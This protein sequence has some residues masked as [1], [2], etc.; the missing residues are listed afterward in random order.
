MFDDETQ[1]ALMEEFFS[2]NRE[3]LGRIEKGLLAL[4]SH[5]S[6]HECINA[7]FRDMH[8][9]KGNCRMMGFPRMEALAHKAETILDRMREDN[10]VLTQEIG[11]SL[12][13]VVDRARRTLDV[14]ARSGS[15][16]ETD[17]STILDTLERFAN[18]PATCQSPVMARCSDDPLPVPVSSPQPKTKPAVSST[19]PSGKGPY[20]P[21]ATV[22][23]IRLSLSR[24]DTLMN[25]VG[26]L[27]A[28]FNQLKYVL[29]HHPHH[30]EQ[31]IEL[32]GKQIQW[33][34]SEV[35]KYRL[36]PIGQIWDQY[37]RLVRDLSVEIG[38]KVILDL[39]GEETEIDRNVLA[40]INELLGHMIRNAMDHGIEFSEERTRHGKSPIGRITLSA[41]QK[42]GQIFLKISDDGRG[43]DPAMVLKKALTMQLVTL[44][45]SS[46]MTDSEIVRLIMAPGFSTA[47]HVSTISGRGTGM[48]VVKAALDKIGGTITIASTQGM[49]SVFQIV[50]PQTMAIVPSLL[51]Q[52]GG[53]TFALPQTHIVE[54]VSFYGNDVTANV[55]GK[56]QAPM[57]RFREG[58]IPLVPLQ[59]LV[60]RDG[61]K[62][63]SR[64]E[65]ERMHQASALHIVVLQVQENLF[66]LEV[67][68]ILGHT[69]L[70]IKP[71]SRI[72][73]HISLLAGSAVM[74]DGSISF[75]LNVPALFQSHDNSEQSKF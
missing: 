61:P 56:M 53:E 17:F 67:D 43:I 44:E 52:D 70:L 14:I 46:E 33:L 58:L 36:Q 22:E 13:G 3:A 62:R 5:P 12:L 30:V 51:I 55:E 65:I 73:S 41:E 27:G 68:A 69:S 4:E 49:G 6:D 25:Q 37:H 50:I 34:Q 47:S 59:R 28:S 54:L 48:D 26:E 38:K 7:V 72:F 71:I 32:H 20:A 45:Q 60:K 42:H 66:G 39:V 64:R 2:E 8:T 40:V 16:G 24:L 23:S 21:P 9:V 31:V 1:K 10:M 11:S 18:L 75:L 19:V 15:E 63:S 35:I 29:A 57:V 74:P